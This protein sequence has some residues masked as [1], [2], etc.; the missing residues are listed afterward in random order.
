MRVGSDD[1]AE[2]EVRDGNLMKNAW[3]DTMESYLKEKENNWYQTPSNVV[4][5]LVDPISGKPVSTDSAHKKIFYYIKGTQPLSDDNDLEAAF[6]EMNEE[7]KG[8]SDPVS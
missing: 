3:I 6:H 7:K 4:G 8:D 5:V 2:T 1:K